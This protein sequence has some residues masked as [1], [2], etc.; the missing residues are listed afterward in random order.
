MKVIGIE[1]KKGTFND[2]TREV[3]YDVNYLHCTENADCVIGERTRSYKINGRVEF[4]GFKDLTELMGK[5]VYIDMGFS[6]QYGAFV[7][8][9][10]CVE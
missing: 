3:D 6:K 4:V 5:N 8:R 9:L 10:S 2:G 7:R 1:N